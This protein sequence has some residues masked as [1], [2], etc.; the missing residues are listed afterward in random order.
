[1][2]CTKCG[3]KN[4]DDA[5]FCANCGS[6]VSKK[7]N[8][9]GI[10]PVSN[11]VEPVKMNSEEA[12]PEKNTN[13]P[14]SVKPIEE[15][16]PAESEQNIADIQPDIVQKVV[17]FEPQMEAVVETETVNQQVNIQKTES[18]Q[19][20]E[21]VN[22]I[23]NASIPVDL[24]RSPY[25]DQNAGNTYR[26]KSFSVPR[27]L[28]SM[29]IMLATICSIVTIAFDYVGVKM[30]M[31]LLGYSDSVSESEYMK[32]FDIIKEKV[33][34]DETDDF[35]DMGGNSKELE[36]SLNT[37]RYFVIA[38]AVAMLVFCVIDFI[39]LSLVR[40]K[41]AYI[42][43]MLFAIIKAA[44]GSVA[45]YLWTVDALGEY[46]KIMKLAFEEYS[47]YNFNLT[48][49]F[50]PAV[51]LILALAMQA[52]IFISAIVLLCTKPKYKDVSPQAIHV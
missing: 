11:I 20:Q 38:F 5:M 52:V 33:D 28:F 36:D 49:E 32:G 18:V 37:F 45:I 46:E 19:P 14:E 10:Q 50:V 48:L 31:E 16:Q 17:E 43:T 24:Y 4:E 41:I 13:I 25:T 42:L 35:T 7:P 44:L 9:E 26:R 15:V 3:Y 39:L 2:Y 51:G 1:M 12:E 40:N 22:N 27:F 29:I 30:K 8:N 6:V 23:N 47:D 21:V 34:I